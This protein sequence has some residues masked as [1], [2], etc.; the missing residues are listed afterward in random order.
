MNI[1]LLVTCSVVLHISVT[2]FQTVPSSLDKKHMTQD[3]DAATDDG[4]EVGF[5]K[6]FLTINGR[7][8]DV[9]QEVVK[10]VLVSDGRGKNHGRCD[11]GWVHGPIIIGGL[12]DSGTRGAK[13]VLNVLLN[14]TMQTASVGTEEDDKIMNGAIGQFWT[15]FLRNVSGTISNETYS[16]A[17]GFHTMANELCQAVQRDWELAGKPLGAWG[18]KSPRSILMTPVWNYMFGDNYRFVHVVR[19]PRSNCEKGANM[20]QYKHACEPLLSSEE[21]EYPQGCF[22]YWTKVNGD[23]H[24]MFAKDR[25]GSQ[26]VFM[27]MDRLVLPKPAIASA[28]FE[29]V[30]RELAKL[31]ERKIDDARALEICATEHDYAGR[32]KHHSQ[33]TERQFRRA[34]KNDA[35]MSE[36]ASLLGYNTKKG[37]IVDNYELI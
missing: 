11:G 26:Y 6:T 15:T 18:F 9:L 35:M 8:L 32:Y 36:V 29:M 2:G 28:S 16:S 30:R 19:D 12:S 1:F 27:S 4:S 21:C 14:I 33:K 5:E 13:F 22:K 17:P 10:A 34:A 25:L 37:G 20:I 31:P 24:K 23:V 7:Q 3:Y